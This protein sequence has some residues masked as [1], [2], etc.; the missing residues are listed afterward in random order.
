MSAIAA[1]LCET[2]KENHP[3]CKYVLWDRKLLEEFIETQHPS[4][5]KLLQSY[6]YDIQRIDVYKYL[7]LY[8]YGGVYVD[9]D[10]EN[11]KNVFDLFGSHDCYL[12]K[13]ED[14]PNPV[15]GNCFIACQPQSQFIAWLLS[16]LEEAIHN[17]PTELDKMNMVLRT[18][19]P[20]FVTRTYS[21]FH[22]KKIVF[23][24]SSCHVSPLLANES[25][26]MMRT[27]IMSPFIEDKMSKAHAVHY[28]FT[29]WLRES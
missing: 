7:I 17:T 2:W 11:I 13:E 16:R 3:E 8:H 15:I 18:T 20:I 21:D 9:V 24:L 27:G 23:L 28:F 26:E 6:T 5:Q 22:Q 10:V 29:T 12:S 25:R 19:G 1:E 14:S 4:F